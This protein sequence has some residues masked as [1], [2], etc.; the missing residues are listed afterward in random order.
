MSADRSS[1]DD[2]IDLF[3]FFETLWDGK[4]LISAFVVLA[5]L[6]GFGYWQVVKP[7]YYVSV[8]YNSNL[9]S[10]SVQQM[11]DHNSGCM[12]TYTINHLLSFLGNNWKRDN[13]GSSLSFST[14]SPLKKSD[15]EAQIE[16]ANTSLTNATFLEASTEIAIIEADMADA[17]LNSE[18]VA[19]NM[20]NAKRLIHSI[21]NGQRAITF[22]SV[23]VTKSSP[24]LL[25]ILFSSVLFGGIMGVSFILISNFIKNRKEQLSQA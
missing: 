16:Q 6:I 10:L 9:V 18:I 25:L 3:E 11:C 12:D 1:Y 2:E 7:N 13:T 21:D 17:L 22:G 8:E 14:S 5:T 15:Y 19:S 23:S 4:W 24:K 20:L